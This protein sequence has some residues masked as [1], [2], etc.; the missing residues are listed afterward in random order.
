[1]VNS[2]RQIYLTD[3]L[4][5]TFAGENAKNRAFCGGEI[6]KSA[7][8][9]HSGINHTRT[10]RKWR[11]IAGRCLPDSPLTHGNRRACRAPQRRC[12]AP[13]RIPL[14]P[15]AFALANRACAFRERSPVNA[16]AGAEQLT[17]LPTLRRRAFDV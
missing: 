16:A 10:L 7:P 6:F 12:G 13:V 4:N 14:P 2:E 8:V 17:T 1:M 3:F 9:Y 5:R 15:G 11:A